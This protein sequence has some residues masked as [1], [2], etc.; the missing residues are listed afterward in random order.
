M[1]N[2][3]VIMELGGKWRNGVASRQASKQASKQARRAMMIDK[4][5]GTGSEVR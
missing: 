3:G 4:Q 2:N 1:K 5:Y